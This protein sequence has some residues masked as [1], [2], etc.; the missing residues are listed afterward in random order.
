[1]NKGYKAKK[2]YR[3]PR[4]NH[5]FDFLVAQSFGSLGNEGACVFTS[6]SSKDWMTLLDLEAY[7]STKEPACL[8]IMRIGERGSEVSCKCAMAGTFSSDGNYCQAI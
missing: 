2:F 3:N 7:I 5:S 6:L 4:L 1:M 8:M